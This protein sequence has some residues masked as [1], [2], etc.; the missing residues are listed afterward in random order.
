MDFYLLTGA[1]PLA[2]AKFIYY[3]DLQVVKITQSNAI[4]NIVNSCYSGHPRDCSFTTI[5]VRVCN[6]GVG[7]KSAVNTQ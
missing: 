4:A 7:E 2:L 3:T 5:I 1:S 6:S